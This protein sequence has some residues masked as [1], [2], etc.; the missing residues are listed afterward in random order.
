MTLATECPPCTAICEDEGCGAAGGGGGGGSHHRC[1]EGQCLGADRESEAEQ[2][3]DGDDEADGEQNGK[4]NN[5]R[6]HIIVAAAR[7]DDPSAFADILGFDDVTETLLLSEGCDLKGCSP[8]ACPNNRHFHSPCLGLADEPMCPSFCRQCFEECGPTR[9]ETYKP[10]AD[11][12]KMMGVIFANAE[13]AEQCLL[14]GGGGGGEQGLLGGVNEGG[15]RPADVFLVE[16]RCCGGLIVRGE[17]EWYIDTFLSESSQHQAGGGGADKIAAEG[18]EGGVPSRGGI[19]VLRQTP[20][21]CPCCR[22][23]PLRPS[24]Y[25]RRKEALSAHWAQLRAI[26]RSEARALRSARRSARLSLDD[27]FAALR[28]L[29]ESTGG[30]GA[31]IELAEIERL[32]AGGH[33]R[34]FGAAAKGLAR[35]ANDVTGD[36]SDDGD[37]PPY[38]EALRCLAAVRGDG[39]AAAEGSPVSEQQKAKDAFVRLAPLF[40]P[41][42]SSSFTVSP[43]L[44]QPPLNSLPQSALPA[45]AAAVE[46][47]LSAVRKQEAEAAMG[48]NSSGCPLYISSSF[49]SYRPSAKKHSSP[50]INDDA[51]FVVGLAQLL[52]PYAAEWLAIERGRCAAVEDAFAAFTS[53]EFTSNFTSDLIGAPSK[54]F[55]PSSQSSSPQSSS[56][57]PFSSSSS[58]P[59]VCR[60][61]LR[62]YLSGRGYVATAA[63][64]AFFVDAPE[65]AVAGGQRE[66]G[67]MAKSVRQRSRGIFD[68]DT[69]DNDSDEGETSHDDGKHSFRASLEA[70]QRGLR[71]EQHRGRLQ[72][73]LAAPAAPVISDAKQLFSSSE[74][75]FCGSAVF[76]FATSSA[77]ARQ[78][79]YFIVSLLQCLHRLRVAY[80]RV[81]D[82]PS[83]EIAAAV[84]RSRL[85]VANAQQAAAGEEGEGCCF[86][87][88]RASATASCAH[89][90]CL[91]CSPRVTANRP[92]PPFFSFRIFFYILLLER[93]AKRG[94]APP[95]T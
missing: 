8:N 26:R 65:A 71:M 78:Q 25:K 12:F 67:A 52:R 53:G 24:D 92:R 87:R 1:G 32:F 23:S 57:S 18:A 15:V 83:G 45:F 85:S 58:V 14:V 19:T 48:A 27:G 93:P 5:Q 61:L 44:H 68:S 21:L 39:A 40:A 54:P 10:F 86:L 60:S 94:A 56:S 95:K 55:T 50:L 30:R 20:I 88:L 89:H 59:D 81:A 74:G 13:E 64:E 75:A 28:D 31:L 3:E 42:S 9:R 6:R 84:A 90:W 41:H 17:L 22:R 51:D 79:L 46:V 33:E 77:E 73:A 49:A 69:S 47:L 34:A 4:K 16:M 29:L 43:Q 72:A 91:R 36:G 37:G 70:A 66:G 35:A 80:T 82:M 2:S 7:A 62:V 76:E 63:D 38:A 11:R